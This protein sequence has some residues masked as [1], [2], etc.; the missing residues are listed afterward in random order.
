VTRPTAA[1]FASLIDS[2][3]VVLFA[4]IH[5]QTHCAYAAGS[6]IW[7]ARPYDEDLDARTNLCAMSEDLTRFV[8]AAGELRLDA[9]V[10]ALPGRFGASI[11]TLA[12]TVHA[13]LR[14]FTEHDPLG[15][16]PLDPSQVEDP[17]WCFTFGGD[18]LF[19]NTFAPCYPERHSRYSFGAAA[20]FVLIQ[21]RHSFARV[22]RDGE[23]VL[24]VAVRSKIRSDYASHGRGYDVEISAVPF[25]AYRIVRPL[26]AGDRPVRWWEAPAL[27][28]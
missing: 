19:V 15:G 14:T 26:A 10:V 3:T 6:V 28:P 25:E 13:V 23:T 1:A 22:V 21:P 20:T 24:P 27:F 9:L 17:A 11:A 16:E 5:R 8:D 7:G 2:P 4:P 18:P 12:Q